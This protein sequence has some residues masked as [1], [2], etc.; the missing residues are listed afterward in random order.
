VVRGPAGRPE[1]GAAVIAG[2]DGTAGDTAVLDFAF[3]HASRHHVALHAVLCWRPDLLASMTWRAEPPPPAHVEAWLSQSLGGW[4]EKY[5]DVPVHD[6][7]VR[8]HPVAGLVAASMAQYLLVVGSRGRHAL[9]GT[10]LGSVS[11]GVLHHAT[12]P[13]AVVPTHGD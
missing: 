9:A 8:D 11:Q 1:E 13:V 5:P 3:E 10:L 4:R 2:V 6:L 7:V 12:C